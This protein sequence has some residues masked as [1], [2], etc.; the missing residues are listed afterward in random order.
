MKKKIHFTLVLVFS[1]F[2]IFA[3]SLSDSTKFKHLS[4][5]FRAGKDVWS[6]VKEPVYSRF[7]V[8]VDPIKY[9][10]LDFQVGRNKETTSQDVS[11]WGPVGSYTTTLELQSKSFSYAVGAFGMYN[12]NQT[13]VYLGYRFGQIKSSFDNVEFSS[14]PSGSAPFV[15][16]DYVN[17]NIHTPCI[18]GEHFFGKWFS[19]GAEFGY[20]MATDKLSGFSYGA[21]TKKN[22]SSYSDASLILRFY[23][24]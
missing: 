22:K 14:G 19:L 1:G 24:I 8:S 9:L 23:I 7:L 17:T 10:R 6:Q 16:T 2:I 21:K 15:G 13:R 4:I 11:G 5:G 18:G 20:N 3:S 12:F